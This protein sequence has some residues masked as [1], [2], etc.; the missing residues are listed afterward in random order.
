MCSQIPSRFFANKSTQSRGS[1]V[2]CALLRHY[3]VALNKPR[4]VS[5]D[6]WACCDCDALWPASLIDSSTPT[7]VT[8]TWK[9]IVTSRSRSI[10]FLC[11]SFVRIDPLRCADPLRS[12]FRI[13]IQ[14]F[15]GF[16]EFC[17]DTQSAVTALHTN[18][19]Y[20]PSTHCIDLIFK[21]NHEIQRHSKY[22]I[23]KTQ[24]MVGSNFPERFNVKWSWVVLF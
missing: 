13:M 9:R 22:L 7:H 6:L 15:G 16:L 12:L 3:E 20:P 24:D 18:G 11:A 14:I 17:N 1:D 5:V 8:H 19:N 10:E 4:S 21:S 23:K 2:N